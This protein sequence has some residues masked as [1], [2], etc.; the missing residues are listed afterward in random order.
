M[1]TKDIIKNSVLENFTA[2]ISL[3]RVC[4]SLGL[5]VVLSLYMF[6]IYRMTTK[7]SFY[8]KEFNKSIA[9]MSVIT[10]A[11]VASEPVPEVVGIA[12]ITGTFLLERTLS[13]P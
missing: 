5:A 12:H 4:I 1:S 2:D 9:L 10:A 8:S 7:S 3:T 11:I 13:T 6:Y